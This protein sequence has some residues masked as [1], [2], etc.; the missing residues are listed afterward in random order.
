MRD[1]V[2]SRAFLLTIAAI[3]GCSAHLPSNVVRGTVTLDGQ[4]LAEGL[5]HFIAVDGSVATTE[6]RIAAGKFEAAVPPGEKRVEIRAGKVTGKKRVY[7]TPDSPTVDLVS[8]LVPA[9][10]NVQS[11]L[12]V[13]VA[14][15]EQEE[16][17]ELNS[18]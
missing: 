16:T 5:I 17:F 15:G 3:I 6:A 8:E 10:Y 12:R 11:E 13:T 18:N 2:Q 4:P 9:R 7:D 14:E 1:V